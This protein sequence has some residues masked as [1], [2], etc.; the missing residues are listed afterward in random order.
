MLRIG[1]QI[2]FPLR[3]CENGTEKSTS[4]PQDATHN[5][6][7]AFNRQTARQLIHFDSQLNDIQLI[8]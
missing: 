3:D 5:G 2:L 7:L 8:D 6:K 1:D 4:I